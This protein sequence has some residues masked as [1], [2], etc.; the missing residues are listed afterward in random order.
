MGG[1]GGM[2]ICGIALALALVLGRDEQ[3]AA[4]SDT[5]LFYADNDIFTEKR[6]SHAP[7]AASSMYVCR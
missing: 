1:M 3:G 5:I 4:S 2:D 6:A 7:R